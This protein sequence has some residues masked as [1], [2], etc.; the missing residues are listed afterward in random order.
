MYEIFERIFVFYIC[1]KF[2][3]II[4]FWFTMDRNDKEEDYEE[5]YDYEEER[6]YYKDLE[7]H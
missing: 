4:Y 6:Y 5:D 3:S 7:K 1:Y 2:V